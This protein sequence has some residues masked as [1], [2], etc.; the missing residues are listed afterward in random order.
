M[1]EHF[2]VSVRCRNEHLSHSPEKGPTRAV[3][4]ARSSLLSG[5]KLFAPLTSLVPISE[6]KIEGHFIVKLCL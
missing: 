2:K 3:G 1:W 6:M 5:L 4:P